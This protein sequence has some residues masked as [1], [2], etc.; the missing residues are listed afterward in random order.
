M[1]REMSLP[2][3]VRIGPYVYQ[4]REVEYLDIDD[5]R[6]LGYCS[7]VDHTISL[8]RGL[9]ADMRRNAVLHELLHA[10]SESFRVDINADEY[11]VERLTVGLLMLFDQNPDLLTVLFGCRP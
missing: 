11:V 9:P 3:E 7:Y 2:V 6:K 5:R 4:M 10:V 1:D 8:V